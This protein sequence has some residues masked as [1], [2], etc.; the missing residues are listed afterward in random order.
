MLDTEGDLWG[1]L[2]AEAD[3][4]RLTALVD[5]GSRVALPSAEPLEVEREESIE[6]RGGRGT[7]KSNF[8][9][10]WKCHQGS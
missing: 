3:E 7:I 2:P 10:R 6:N 4:L 8:I 5:R 9:S 1:A